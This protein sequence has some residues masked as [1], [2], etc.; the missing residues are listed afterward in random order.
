MSHP[1][2]VR[3]LKLGNRL[4]N[5]KNRNVAPHGGAWIE[6]RVGGFAAGDARVAP[7]GGA[8]IE[9]PLHLV[10]SGIS[11]Y[12]APHGGAWIETYYYRN[13]CNV[14]PSHPTGVRG[15]KHGV[16][17]PPSFDGRRTPRG[18]VD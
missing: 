15:L 6:T 8:W 7:H 14:Q 13:D 5:R 4:E 2:G 18:C 10:R 11:G 3:G 16:S 12:V 9:T 17:V 1:T